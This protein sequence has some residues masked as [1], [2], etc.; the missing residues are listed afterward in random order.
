MNWPSLSLNTSKIQARVNEVHKL[1][2][3]DFYGSLFEFID[4][5]DPNK[6]EEDLDKKVR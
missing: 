6:E 2:T 1:E 3:S 5:D 4:R